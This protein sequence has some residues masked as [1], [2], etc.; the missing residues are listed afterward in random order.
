M[1]TVPKGLE[2][3]GFFGLAGIDLEDMRASVLSNNTA[4]AEDAKAVKR[5]AIIRAT[6]QIIMRRFL[7][8]HNRRQRREQRFAARRRQQQRLRS[9]P[10]NFGGTAMHVSLGQDLGD[11]LS[12]DGDGSTADPS[13]LNSTLNA[14]MT[15][16]AAADEEEEEMDEIEINADREALTA[17]EIVGEVVRLILLQSLVAFHPEQLRR[18]GRQVPL[19]LSKAGTPTTRTRDNLRQHINAYTFPSEGAADGQTAAEAAAKSAAAAAAAAAAASAPTIL[20]SEDERGETLTFYQY[21]LYGTIPFAVPPP[22]EVLASPVASAIEACLQDVYNVYQR[23]PKL[24]EAE[25][26][27]KRDLRTRLLLYAAMKGDALTV[28]GGGSAAGASSSSSTPTP[29]HDYSPARIDALIAKYSGLGDRL[30]AMIYEKYGPPSH[31][32]DLFC[33]AA[34]GLGNAAAGGAAAMEE[35]LLRRASLPHGA[36][37]SAVSSGNSP[38]RQRLS[39]REGG[40]RKG[41]VLGAGGPLLQGKGATAGRGGSV[42]AAADDNHSADGSTDYDS[43]GSAGGGPRRSLEGD[44]N[45]ASSAAAAAIASAQRIARRLTPQQL[46]MHA[47]AS[48]AIDTYA[49]LAAEEAAKAAEAERRRAKEEEERKATLRTLF[50]DFEDAYAQE[51]HVKLFRS[52]GMRDDGLGPAEDSEEEEEV[53]IDLV[54]DYGGAHRY[55]HSSSAEVGFDLGFKS[56]N[57]NGGDNR[58]LHASSTHYPLLQQQQRADSLSPLMRAETPSASTQRSARLTSPSSAGTASRPL[59]PPPQQQQQQQQQRR[60]IDPEDLLLL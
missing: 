9:A 37:L 57:N 22:E 18:V 8:D 32:I 15:G 50:D 28:M 43:D 39:A 31:P 25:L 51:A 27:L 29:P 4:F 38:S 46:R 26:V 21:E 23:L 47:V 16:V 33:E 10:P 24:F 45:N 12:S 20:T 58:S 48:S 53:E 7:R 19:L 35:A 56:G 49:R 55:R 42:G 3:C 60:Q 13:S 59:S 11:L 52:L 17:E 54:E 30:E 41:T 36:R 40:R 14:T 2:G 5:D 6:Q 44:R 1:A 34:E